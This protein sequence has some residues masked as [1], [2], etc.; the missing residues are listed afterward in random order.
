MRLPPEPSAERCASSKTAFRPAVTDRA[1][2]FS[3][4]FRSERRARTDMNESYRWK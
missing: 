4:F 2:R 1:Y 3:A